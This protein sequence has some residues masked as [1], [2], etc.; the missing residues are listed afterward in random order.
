M[1][2]L[3]CENEI[4]LMKNIFFEPESD[5]NSQQIFNERSQKLTLFKILQNIALLK[6][7]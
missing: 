2:R 1:Q 7:N 6:I 4:E 3:Q 5:D